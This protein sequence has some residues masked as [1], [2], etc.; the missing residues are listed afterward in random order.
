VES[1]VR[2][3][4][5]AAALLASA[6]T[7]WIVSVQ[8]MRGMEAGP[9]ADLGAFGRFIMI[10]VTMMAAMMLPSA[11]PAV[12]MFSGLRR[13]APAG[14]FVAG[15][16]L[17]W[18]TV[19]LA[20]YAAFRGLRELAPSFAAWEERG[21]WLAGSA[22]VAAGLYQL[23]P[24][25]TACLRHCRAPVGFLLR[26]RPGRTGAVR[27][28][29]GHGAYCIGCCAGL[30]LALRARRDEP[31]L[32]GSRRH[33]DPGRESSP[34]ARSLGARPPSPWSRPASGWRRHPKACRD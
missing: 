8:Q 7:A 12:L 5:L 19:G 31:R 33:P 15:Y 4:A 20:A 27:T 16:L 10:W 32:D 9:G 26:S 25:K 18:T 11:A 34:M 21:P 23:T 28:G 3:S 1:A 14:A 17:A 29:F 30:M 13:G 22:L 2:R 6:L 24:L